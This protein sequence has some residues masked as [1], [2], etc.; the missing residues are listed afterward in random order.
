M[1]DEKKKVKYTLT[2]K[3]DCTM[4][5][6]V[7]DVEMMEELKEEEL[8]KLLERLPY[9]IPAPEDSDAPVKYDRSMYMG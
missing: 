1:G 6:E 2:I 3:N 4:D 5:A 8:N 7:P 9:D